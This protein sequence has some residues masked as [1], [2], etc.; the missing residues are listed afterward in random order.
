MSKQLVTRGV[1]LAPMILATLVGCSGAIV[2]LP[3]TNSDGGPD[4]GLASSSEGGLD[5]GPDLGTDLGVDLGTVVGPALV[6]APLSVSAPSKVDLLLMIDNSSSMADKQS[7]LT[8]RVPALVQL[9]THPPTVSGG[10]APLAI[11]DI[12][13]GVITS[14]LGSYGTDACDETIPGNEYNDHGHLLPRSAAE[15][16]GSGFSADSSGNPVAA[17][18]PAPVV[19]AALSWTFD[20]SVKPTA[21]FTGAT[22]VPSLEAA[23]S[24]V[25]QSAHEDGCGYEASLESVYHFLID[26]KPYQSAAATCAKAPGGVTCNTDITM[27]GVDNALLAQRAAFLRP[28]SL[29]AVVIMTDENDAS[30]KPAGANWVFAGLPGGT[31]DHDSSMPRGWA[32]CASLPDDYEDEDYH[33]LEAKGCYW[34]YNNNADANCSV[35]WKLAGSTDWD[36][37]NLR[38]FEETRR[39]GVNGLYSRQ[40]YVDGFTRVTVLGSDGTM[41]PNGIFVG[42]R[43]TDHVVVAAIVGVPERLVNDPSTGMPKDLGASDWDLLVSPDHT[44]RDPHM[45]ESITPRPGVPHFKPSVTPDLAAMPSDFADA[46]NGGDRDIPDNH[47]L[48][49]ACLGVRATTT[50]DAK[51]PD[52]AAGADTDKTNPVCGTG[53]T[54][55]PR[56]KAY[57]GLRELRVLHEIGLTG[58]G[59]STVA[60]SICAQSFA[61]AV[62][63]IV[64]KLQGALAGVCFNTSLTPDPATMNVNCALEEVFA[65]SSIGG[66]APDAAGACEALGTGHCTPG[67]AP[68]RREATAGGANA[69]TVL[70][71]AQAAAQLSLMVRQYDSTTGIVAPTPTPAYV[72]PGGNVFLDTVDATGVKTTHLVCEDLQLADGRAGVSQSVT[73]ACVSAPTFTLPAGLDGGWCYSTAVAIIG[74]NCLKRGSV[75]TMRFLGSDQPRAGSQVFTVCAD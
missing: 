37:R 17:S 43:T 4:T 69:L 71:V 31:V 68:C 49:Y 34:C 67:S 15:A 62:Q 45:I 20:P 36:Q 73:D 55:Q 39:F 46:I 74:D 25:V 33:N 13:V 18:C 30:L 42:G 60:A 54:T 70:P 24:C 16:S 32:S 56:Y 51:Y 28:D 2:P 53:G 72:S 58:A 21:Q 40:R 14:S 22:G 9:L 12:H 27:T 1:V 61:P 48:Q 29:L 19:S 8:R 57:P 3:A 63:S 5:A 7:E 50:P 64:D 52:C 23:V 11:P 38:M 41:G 59:V 47:D 10:P 26:P 35:G 6:T 75:G 44:K 66:A 65:T